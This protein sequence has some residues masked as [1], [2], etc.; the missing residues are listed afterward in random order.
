MFT[1]SRNHTA[2]GHKGLTM[3]ML[4]K[5]LAKAGTS[6]ALLFGSYLMLV[7]TT[8]HA[9]ALENV[10]FTVTVE[11]AAPRALG[12]SA[13]FSAGA[14]NFAEEIFGPGSETQHF[15]T[16]TDL[17]VVLTVN[18]GTGVL[19]G[20]EG[21]FT[22]T[23]T[24]GAQYGFRRF[25]SR[26]ISFVENPDTT[27][28]ATVTFT[29]TG[30]ENPGGT[31][32]DNHV[33]FILRATEAGDTQTDN[34]ALQ[35]GDRIEMVIP[36][37]LN[38]SNFRAP[39]PGA[40]EDVTRLVRVN[41]GSR[42]TTSVGTPGFGTVTEFGGTNDSANIV[43]AGA[44][45]LFRVVDRFQV[46][47]ARPDT[48]PT[49][50][51]DE[52]TEFEDAAVSITPFGA[53]ADET[54]QAIAIGLLSITKSTTD[55]VGQDGETVLELLTGDSITITVDGDFNEGAV[56]F[57][58]I[59][60]DLAIGVGEAIALGEEGATFG[61]VSPLA[62][63]LQ[64][65][66][67]ETVYFVT[68]GDAPLSPGTYT[69]TMQVGY[70]PATFLDES[71]TAPLTTTN[72]ANIFEDGFA[73]AVPGCV[74]NDRIRVRMTN[75]GS[76]AISVFVQGYDDAGADLGFVEMDASMVR[77]S[78]D[79]TIAPNETLVVFTRHFEQIFGASGEMCDLGDEM[80]DRSSVWEGEAQ[81]TFFASGNLTILPLV[82]GFDREL[83]DLGG[84]T[85]LVIESGASRHAITK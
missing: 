54:L 66:N 59:D 19:E 51:I 4:G 69:V 28:G 9:Q 40:M 44:N 68:D 45:V 80:S 23:L 6:A 78:G 26:D 20:S 50:D 79:S 37:L 16:L 74:H 57:V 18:D 14:L 29:Q 53:A 27:N 12:E 5:R 75:E 62:T 30:V 42:S 25:D 46:V 1:C 43:A 8:A 82:R 58:D 10:T 22:F 76:S 71:S 38:L 83:R 61:G 73:Y 33:T 24:N 85:G 60:G 72:F 39:A 2:Q 34:Y 63:A 3:I 65:D 32:G 11:S 49:I 36:G 77:G 70:A 55:A 56:A 35:P 21:S 47:A 7:S 52:R 13:M 67:P 15:N 64:A 41:V 84:F 81:M 31:I 17:R 48:V